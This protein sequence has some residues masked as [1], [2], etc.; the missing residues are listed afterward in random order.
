V[1]GE[2]QRRARR[3]LDADGE[4]DVTGRPRRRR[5]DLDAALHRW[6]VIMLLTN[7]GALLVLLAGAA[8]Y[9]AGVRP[10]GLWLLAGGV[11]LLVLGSLPV[12]LR[13]S[14]L[15]GHVDALN[16]A[17]LLDGRYGS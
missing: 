8:L 17:R 11:A 12:T 5:A 3:G 1:H 2:Q 13:W 15:S 7:G 16:A 4:P 14:G 10:A 9:V 6:F